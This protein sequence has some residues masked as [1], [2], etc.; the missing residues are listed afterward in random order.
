MEPNPPMSE[1]G[2]TPAPAGVPTI[3]CKECG[4]DVPALDYCVRC[5]D[6]LADE[7]NAAA[8]IGRRQSYAAHP[9]ER[10]LAVNIV[11]TLFPQLPR[12][13][14]A[15][16]RIVLAIGVVTIIG[17]AAAGL[18]PLAL[19]AAELLV[20][21]MMVLYIWDVDVYEDEPLRVMVF[22]TAWGIVAGII[23]G[24]AIRLLPAGGG[25][26][27]APSTA[28]ILGRSVL[29]PLAGGLAMLAG[30]LILLPYR[31]FNDVLDG[32]TFGATAAVAFTAAQVL[33]QATEFFTNGLQP[34]GDSLPWIVRLLSLG[35][36]MPLVA[37]GVIGSAAAAFWLRYRAP[38]R[39]RQKL[40]LVG[41]PIVATAIAFLI[42]IAA[43][44]GQQLLPFLPALLWLALLAVISL[45]WL[46]AVIHLGLLEEAAEI[47][48][49]PPIACPHCGRMTPSHSFCGNCG[50]SLRATPKATVPQGGVLRPDQP[51]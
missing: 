3:R 49:G 45:L 22:T 30:P 38:L 10:A 4:N 21:L 33:S 20:P 35:I 27:G 32:A 46:R 31:K 28:A 43:A 48:I 9:D 24:L 40:G 16:F 8:L 34:P 15:T 7:K 47:S 36:A 17:L 19:V 18:F 29:V 42:L 39:D 12:A 41:Q 50:A 25:I 6:P 11:S 1:P 26:L 23:V 44:L 5:G 13:D 51:G 2:G 37:A 14:M